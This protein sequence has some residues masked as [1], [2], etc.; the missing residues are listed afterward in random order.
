MTSNGADSVVEVQAYRLCRFLDTLQS[1]GF[2]LKKKLFSTSRTATRFFR[3]VR[4]AAKSA[5]S[6][7]M[8]ACLSVRMEQ[9]DSHW[10]E[11]DE[12]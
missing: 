12:I 5:V 3:P 6:F 4:T 2:R 1:G 9:L 8:F 11:F 7:F 10:T